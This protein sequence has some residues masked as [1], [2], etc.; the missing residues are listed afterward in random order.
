MAR[1]QGAHPIDANPLVCNRFSGTSFAVANAQRLLAAPVDQR[2]DLDEAAVGVRLD[3]R[4]VL[5]VTRLVA[6][7]AGEPS[8]RAGE[9]AVERLDLADMAAGK[10]CVAGLVEAVDTL[11]L[12]QRFE[13]V[14]PGA[15]A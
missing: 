1:V 2:V 3:Q 10:S 7:Q 4:H 11:P 13:I 6:A 8:V 5:A 15:I 9:R 12:H 14:I